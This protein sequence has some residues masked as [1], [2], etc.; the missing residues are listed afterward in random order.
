M[1]FLISIVLIL[2]RGGGRKL[3]KKRKER[4]EKK[5]KKRKKRRGKKIF[6][7]RKCVAVERYLVILTI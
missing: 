5:E 7:A 3:K 4:K 1:I 6:A 2:Y